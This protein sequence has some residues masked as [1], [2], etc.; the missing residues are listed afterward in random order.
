MKTCGAPSESSVN[1]GVG[2]VNAGGNAAI[3]R[4]R[5]AHGGAEVFMRL[6]GPSVSWDFGLSEVVRCRQGRGGTFGIC[7][8]RG[9]PEES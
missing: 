4:V 3:R 2:G 8:W 1:K 6:C 7:Y 5:D 9:W